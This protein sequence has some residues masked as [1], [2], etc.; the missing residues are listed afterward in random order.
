MIFGISRVRDEDDIVE[1]S[2]RRMLRQ[3]DHV[4]V[5]EGNSSDNTRPILDQLASETDR[6]T[7][8][9]DTA[10]NFEQRDVMTR[11]AHLAREMGG[12]WGVFFD[13]DEAWYSTDGKIHITLNNLPG[14]I[15]IAT[16]R[17]L[18]HCA[19]SDDDPDEPDP[20]TRM[21]WRSVEMLPL[22]KVACRL[23]EDL[24]V[25]HG[26]HS[27]AYSN[28]PYPAA[29]NG[30]LESRH[31]PY[32]SPEQFVKRVKVAWPMLR[33]SGLPETHG[34]HMWAYGRHLDEFGEE[35]LRQWFAN[36]MHF[37]NPAANPEL[38]HDPLP[39]LVAA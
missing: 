16:A 19:T 26:N 36:G 38:V 25:G 11:Y 22:G 21:E 29:V 12:T 23:R 7:V 27:A 17:N 5:G 33:D 37:T 4:I 20:M 28:D 8:L 2:I 34:A 35:G 6:L 32:R 10:R 9:D 24:Q 15:L 18:T 30:L 14:H 39:V 31:F 13:M 1:G 3:V